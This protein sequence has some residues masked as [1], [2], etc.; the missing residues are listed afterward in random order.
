M[1][2]EKEE[3]RGIR[4][5]RGRTRYTVGGLGVISGREDL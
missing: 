5:E 1:S 2:R 4:R 3:V